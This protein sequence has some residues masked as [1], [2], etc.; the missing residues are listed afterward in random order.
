MAEHNLEYR[1]LSAVCVSKGPGSYTGLRVGL[2]VAKGLCYGLDIP[3]LSIDT[4]EIIAT[5]FKE[6]L[7]DRSYIIASIDA[8]RQEI[9]YQIFDRDFKA[10]DEAHNLILEENSFS[11][12]PNSLFCGDG[13][14]KA[15]EIIKSGDLYF[16]HSKPSA[17][18]MVKPAYERFQAGQFENTAYF[19][20]FYLK[21]PNITSSKK[22][23]F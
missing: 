22:P 21:A 15:T 5:A 4:L 1:Q 12:Y 20:P 17:E 11:D 10:L 23:L 19:S 2:S 6:Y 3:L 8:R 9:Y 14:A 7:K 13:A 16:K 18:F